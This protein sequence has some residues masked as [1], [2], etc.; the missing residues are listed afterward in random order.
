VLKTLVETAL[1]MPVDCVGWN[2]KYNVLAVGAYKLDESDTS[3]RNGFVYI[4]EL[5]SKAQN[6]FQYVQQKSLA[7]VLDLKWE[8]VEQKKLAV[9]T[10]NS[11][12]IFQVEVM[13]G[14]PMLEVTH[15][16]ELTTMVLFVQW[17]SLSRVIFSDSGGTVSILDALNEVAPDIIE[18]N[19]LHEFLVW[20]VHYDPDMNCIFSGADDGK[21][22]AFHSKDLMKKEKHY[23]KAFTVGVTS[24]ITKDDLVAV[25]CYDDKLRIFTLEIEN[26]EEPETV[27]IKLV[28]QLE[29]HL[30]GAVWRTI[31]LSPFGEKRENE[32][33]VA[34][35]AAR[36]GVQIVRFNRSSWTG[37]S[38]F[39][40]KNHLGNLA[41]G[42]DVRMDKTDKTYT[43]GTCYFDHNMLHIFKLELF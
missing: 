26:S 31:W 9:G 2:S 29:I 1:P 28:H 8:P 30:G 11:I 35:A 16:V 10:S 24:I 19:Q 7:G 17:M 18:S 39:T 4:V 32:Y 13:Q 41:Y 43:F 36:N 25:G 22:C 21:F 33:Q 38:I 42:L 23:K 37:E 14:R 6:G 20:V 34:V 15:E 40:C 27:K 3:I 12:L 5:D